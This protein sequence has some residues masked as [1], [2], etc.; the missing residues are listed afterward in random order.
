[1]CKVLKVMNLT[2]KV[3]SCIETKKITEDKALYTFIKKHST[4]SSQLKCG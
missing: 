3:P 1:M 2:C 4:V